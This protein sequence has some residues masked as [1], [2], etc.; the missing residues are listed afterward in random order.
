MEIERA[1]VLEGITMNERAIFAES[2]IRWERAG[3]GREHHNW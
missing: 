1:T 2:T 3:T